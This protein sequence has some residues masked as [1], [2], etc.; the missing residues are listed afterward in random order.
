MAAAG[1][2]EDAHQGV[3][4]P[5]ESESAPPWEEIESGRFRPRRI[6]GSYRGRE[7]G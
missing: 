7:L 2:P 6:R 1:I 3:N 4:T 5:P